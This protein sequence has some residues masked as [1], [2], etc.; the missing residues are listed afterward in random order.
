M[1]LT[2]QQIYDR[3]IAGYGQPAWW[4]GTPYAFRLPSFVLDAYTRR[5]LERLGYE[6]KSDDER[7]SFLT[8]GIEHSAEMYAWYHW[9]L[10]EHGKARCGK[11]PKCKGCV[12]GD[13]C[14]GV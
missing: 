1:M 9:A 6:F 12:F 8:K 14:K 13:V 7:R 4:P 10:L 2:S 5:F 3:L 11:R